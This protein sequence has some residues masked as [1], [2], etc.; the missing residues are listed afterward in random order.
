MYIHLFLECRR[1]SVHFARTDHSSS[2]LKS[3]SNHS[4]IL[5]QNSNTSFKSF[6][7]KFKPLIQKISIQT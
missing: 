3:T 2:A 6:Q 5:N 1:P 7:S 4:N